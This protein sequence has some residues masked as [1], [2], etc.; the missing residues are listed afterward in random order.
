VRLPEPEEAADETEAGETEA[1]APVEAEAA[2]EAEAAPEAEPTSTTEPSKPFIAPAKIEKAPPVTLAEVPRAADSFKPA[3]A[4]ADEPGHD[5]AASGPKPWAPAEPKKVVVPPPSTPPPAPLKVE[6]APIKAEE[7]RKAAPIKA[8]E[9]RKAAPIKAEEPRHDGAASGPK[10]QA[11]A[12]PR[13]VAPALKAEEPKKVTPIKAEEPK[14]AVAKTEEPRS[15]PSKKLAKP[16]DATDHEGHKPSSRKPASLRVGGIDDEID[17]SSI[18]AEFFRKD[19][20]SVPPVEEGEEHTV[21]PV[22][23]PVT[24]A[25]R[26]RLRRI[27]AG[28]VSFAGVISIAVVGKLTLAASKRQANTAQTA[29]V[30][31][32]KPLPAKPENK[33]AVLATASAEPA[34]GPTEVAKVE[35]KKPEEAKV[36]EKKADEK[37]PEEAKADEKKADEKKPE[38]AKAEEKK[39]AADAVALK[40]ETESLLNRGKNKDAIVKAREAIEAD[41]TDAMPYL[42]LGSALQE[43]GKWKDGIE[44]YSECV[45]H[46]TKG[47]VHECRAMGGRK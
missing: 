1:A 29:L 30:A 43:T 24:I 13:K 27:V 45:R 7:P 12:E 2:S 22:L 39:P 15:A 34:K 42:Y 21:V 44:A 36:D 28:V 47:P 31:D 16:S 5:G 6:A 40:K 11:P 18:S 19:Q 17:P 26:A 35:D 8:E 10:P 23:S 37:K 38:E 14:R 3:V 25:R 41:P 4:K 33:P 32:A 46:A 20:D 9:P